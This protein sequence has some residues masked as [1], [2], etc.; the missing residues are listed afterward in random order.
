M[1]TLNLTQNLIDKIESTGFV[2]SNGET[3]YSYAAVSEY[4]YVFF[5][6]SPLE[7]SIGFGKAKIAQFL[8]KYGD[9]TASEFERTVS[10]SS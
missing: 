10:F 5:H 7:A 6:K 9:M 2:C 4:I 3:L 1:K 8:K